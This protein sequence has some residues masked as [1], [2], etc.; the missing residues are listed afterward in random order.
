VGGGGFGV[1]GR[2]G[3]QGMRIFI[4]I[5]IILSCSSCGVVAISMRYARVC[6]PVP[7]IHVKCC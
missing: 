7:A 2:G 6:Y 4:R 3:V 1:Q 5:T